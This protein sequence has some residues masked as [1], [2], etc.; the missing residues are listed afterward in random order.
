MP[1]VNERKGQLVLRPLF[2]CPPWSGIVQ[3][4]LSR[5]YNKAALRLLSSVFD[6]TF[7]SY[8][9]V[10]YIPYPSPF[11]YFADRLAI[12]WLLVLVT[13]S[14]TREFLFLITHIP[15]NSLSHISSADVT[16]M[17]SQTSATIMA[18]ETG[19]Q[20]NLPPALRTMTTLASR[21]LTVSIAPHS[22]PFPLKAS[23]LSEKQ[24]SSATFR[25]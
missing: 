7:L 9:T 12:P 3:F 20:H 21:T 25:A 16:T 8:L 4:R 18:R 14:P 13:S 11:F 2:S 1:V 17:L 5:A 19:V 15:S 22:L 10:I 6:V 23:I 24:P